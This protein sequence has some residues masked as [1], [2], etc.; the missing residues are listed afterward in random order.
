[1]RTKLFLIMVA[2][3]IVSGVSVLAV[4]A[5]SHREAPLTSVNPQVDGTDLYAWVDASDPTMVNLV[6]NYYPF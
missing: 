1:M 6:A 3:M 5:S 2:A 4:N